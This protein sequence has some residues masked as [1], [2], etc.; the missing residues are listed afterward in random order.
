MGLCYLL[1]GPIEMLKGWYRRKQLGTIINIS[2]VKEQR[3][4]IATLK[5]VD[6]SKGQSYANCSKKN[7]EEDLAWYTLFILNTNKTTGESDEQDN[8]GTEIH[9]ENVLEWFKGDDVLHPTLMKYE[10]VAACSTI[11]QTKS[12]GMLRKETGSSHTEI[13]NTF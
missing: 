13:I 9:L 4:S 1:D 10:I 12:D 6:W 8:E 5:L 7:L 2:Y 3:D 11:Q